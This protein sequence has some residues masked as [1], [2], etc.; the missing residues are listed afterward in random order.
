MNKNF[1]SMYNSLTSG[2]KIINLS[3]EEAHESFKE[4]A[5]EK[6]K[7]A[8]APILSWYE[9]LDINNKNMLSPRTLDLMMFHYEKIKE[10]NLIID[11]KILAGSNI[12][13]EHL[14]SLVNSLNS[15]LNKY[16]NQPINNV[17]DKI[18]SKR[19]PLEITTSEN[20]KTI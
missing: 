6:Y 19:E 8:A 2:I 1:E 20:K 16:E 18:K 13:N 4:Y 5:L 11:Q 9:H 3:D 7:Q 17:L 10:A 14:D 15:F 12:P